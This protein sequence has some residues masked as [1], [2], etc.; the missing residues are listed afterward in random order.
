MK[1]G[2]ITCNIRFDNPADG[3]NSW[4]HR[5]LFLAETLLKHS[6]DIIAT[7]EGRF[8]QLKD[9]ESLLKDY[10]LIDQ[11]RSWIGERMY[12]TLFVKKNRFEFLQSGDIWL[13]ETPDIAGSLSFESTFPRLM[14]WGKLQLKNSDKRIMIVNTHL[15]HIKKETR[16]CQIGVL[17]C[18]VQKNWMNEGQLF[19]MG[20][21]NDSPDSEVRKQLVEKFTTLKDAWLSKNQI[22]ETSHH[23]FTGEM[24]NGA[25]IDWIMVDNRT[26][27]EECFL[28]KVTQNNRYPTD[29]F[30]VVCKLSL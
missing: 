2:L 29:H 22:E 28:E 19:I 18:E 17:A 9:L 27:V 21:F 23:A 6:P 7:Q 26:K 30:P 4:S 3:E 14:T 16:L 13:S 12:P 25:R 10:D 1:L 15:D 5:R 24:Q 8:H 11:H 20:D